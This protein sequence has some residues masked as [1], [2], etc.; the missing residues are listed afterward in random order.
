LVAA[1]NAAKEISN[2]LSKATNPTS[3]KLDMSAFN[4]S[5]K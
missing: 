4:A 5:L 3:G 2:H 1:A